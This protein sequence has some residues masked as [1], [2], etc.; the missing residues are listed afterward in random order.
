MA[1]YYAKSLSIDP[2]YLI[3]MIGESG[4]DW[5]I[6]V[7]S[8]TVTAHNVFLMDSNAVGGATFVAESDCI[9]GGNNTGWIFTTDYEITT[10]DSTN[11]TYASFT[12]NGT[13]VSLGSTSTTRRGFCYVAG[14]GTP[15]VA[16][17]VVDESGDFPVG[18]FSLSVTGVTTN[19]SYNIRAFIEDAAG[20]HYGNTET[21]LVLPE[22]PIDVDATTT[23]DYI[24]ITWDAVTGATSYNIYW[25]NAFGVTSSSVKITGAASPYLHMDLS[26]GSTYYYRVSAL[27]GTSESALS[28]EVSATVGANYPTFSPDNYLET[29]DYL[30]LL[31]SE[32]QIATNFKQWLEYP[33]EIAKDGMTTANNMNNVFDLDF[34]TGVQL[35]ILGTLLGQTRYLPFQPTDGSDPKLD[36]NMYRKLLKA[37]IL[38]NHW[39]G[40][41]SDIEQKWV[42]IFPG[43][44]IV[45]KDNQDMSID[46]SVTGDISTLIQEMIEYDMIVPR[47]QGVWV[48]YAWAT[49]VQKKFAY[50]MGATTGSTTYDGYDLSSWATE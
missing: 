50:D 14:S 43:T 36:D 11:I 19:V 13:V 46:I 45:I 44:N 8:G 17:S 22:T 42:A 4:S 5:D 29:A 6:S 7:A 26:P 12:A 40:Q 32:Y 37:K 39:D 23:D 47:P 16:D 33:I 18:S 48:N 41:L 30:N 38:L 27:Y 21:T 35:D 20:V 31:T 15:T 28:L 24:T 49:T 10:S 34:A 3:A 9:D 25:A 1:T 2:S